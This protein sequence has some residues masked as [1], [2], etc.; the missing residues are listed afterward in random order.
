MSWLKQAKTIEEYKQETRK[1]DEQSGDAYNG[2]IKVTRLT[3]VLENLNIALDYAKKEGKEKTL[4]VRFIIDGAVKDADELTVLAEETKTKLKSSTN[5]F[6]NY[7]L[8]IA[9][10]IK[11]RIEELNKILGTDY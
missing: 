5:E 2:I 11:A 7:T 6:N 8:S 4:K 10:D 1:I 3:S 9:S